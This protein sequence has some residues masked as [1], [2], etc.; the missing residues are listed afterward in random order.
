MQSRMANMLQMQQQQ[1]AQMQAFCEQ[2]GEDAGRNADDADADH[3][4]RR[5]GSVGMGALMGQMG[6]PVQS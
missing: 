5:R 4:R 1:M 2:S 3:V 6:L